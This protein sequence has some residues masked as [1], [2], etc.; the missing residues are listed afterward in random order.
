MMLMALMIKSLFL[1]I[2]EALNYQRDCSLLILN[3]MTLPNLRKRLV[4]LYIVK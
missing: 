4:L 1:P 3:Q 2:D